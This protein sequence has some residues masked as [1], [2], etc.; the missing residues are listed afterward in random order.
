MNGERI[1]FSVDGMPGVSFF[2]RKLLKEGEISRIDGMEVNGISIPLLFIEK[3]IRREAS[4]S[5]DEMEDLAEC[6]HLPINIVEIIRS[7][8]PKSFSEMEKVIYGRRCRCGELLEESENVYCADCAEML[9]EIGQNHHERE[10]EE[11]RVV[12]FEG[13]VG[14]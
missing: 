5:E 10:A 3:V 1:A 12:A 14:S 9:S 13:I 6:C 2:R 11:F 7:I 4:L 8:S